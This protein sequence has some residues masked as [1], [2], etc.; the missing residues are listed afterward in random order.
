MMKKTLVILFYTL[1]I[2]GCGALETKSYPEN[3]SIT[4]TL[5]LSGG[6]QTM[7]SRMVERK[8]DELLQNSNQHPKQNLFPEKVRLFII[9]TVNLSDNTL[10]DNIIHA[11]EN[12]TN[13]TSVSRINTQSSPDIK[14]IRL[15]SAK[16]GARYTLLITEYANNYQYHNAWTIPSALGLG[17]PYFFLDTQTVM[18][19]SKIEATI[20]DIDQQ[21]ILLNESATAKKE[22]KSTLPDSGLLTYDLKQQALTDGVNKLHDKLMHYF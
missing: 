6:S 22:G 9:N 2:H 14:Q 19:L 18:Y 12:N 8:V 3:Q 11:L 16:H 17:I 20:V 7:S 13:M 10:V 5:E 4:R 21:V 15:L 1:F